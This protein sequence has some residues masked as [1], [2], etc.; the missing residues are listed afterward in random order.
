[1]APD[2]FS[3]NKNIDKTKRNH[4]S[5]Y[6]RQTN[7]NAIKYL[8]TVANNNTNKTTTVTVDILVEC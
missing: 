1:M 2:C 4:Y 7:T 3:L 6:F 5:F 8:K